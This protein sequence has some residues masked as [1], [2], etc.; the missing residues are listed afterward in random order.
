MMTAAR[1]VPELT[2]YP[3]WQFDDGA[4]TAHDLQSGIRM[5]RIENT[6]GHAPAAFDVNSPELDPLTFRLTLPSAEAVFVVRRLVGE[7][8]PDQ[9]WRRPERLINLIWWID[10]SGMYLATDGLAMRP[11]RLLPAAEIATLRYLINSCLVIWPDLPDEAEVHPI[12]EIMTKWSPQPS[13]LHHVIATGDLICGAWSE[14]C[15]ELHT[16]DGYQFYCWNPAYMERVSKEP[17]PELAQTAWSPQK[18]DGVLKL[19]NTEFGVT[20]EKYDR[21]QYSRFVSTRYHVKAPEVEILVAAR[22]TIMMERGGGANEQTMRISIHSVSC[23]ATK[24]ETG[25]KMS[26]D[27]PTGFDKGGPYE[28]G[29]LRIRTLIPVS[30]RVFQGSF[31]RDALFCLP[32]DLAESA[33]RALQVE[34]SGDVLGGKYYSNQTCLFGK[35]VSALSVFN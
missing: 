8:E 12:A 16:N 1:I 20:V 34:I 26:V 22:E 27:I 5:E 35:D 21:N 32:A 24:P 4:S 17:Q 6:P 19:V 29:N 31:V 28:A 13:P 3:V 30:V 15:Y 23:D 18:R 2:S 11:L 10:Y 7:V 14:R 9:F 25:V 33:R